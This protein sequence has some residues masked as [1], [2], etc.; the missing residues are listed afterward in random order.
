MSD[1]A[2]NVAVWLLEPGADADPAI[3][4]RD[5]AITR[6]ELRRRVDALAAALR[7]SGVARGDRVGVLSE[8]V[9]F[10][11]VSYLAAIRSGACVV[12]LAT[13]LDERGFRDAASTT[14]LRRLLVQ[15][16]YASR[17]LGWARAEGVALW[18]ERELEGAPAAEGRIP[19][20]RIHGILAALDEEPLDPRT[21][22]AAIMFTSGSTGRPKGV[23]VSHR[24]IEANTRDIADYL[25]LGPRDRVLAVLPL[26]YCFGASL[27]HTHLR[28][29]G[30]IALASSFMFPEKV[31]DELE[32]R[33][34]T[35][36]AGV[37]STYQILLRSTR[38]ARR[39]FPAL[40]WLQQAGGKLPDAFVRELR[41][42]HPGVALYCMYGQTEATARLSY[43][44]PERLD[45]KPGSIGRGLSGTRLEVLAEGGRPVAPEEETGEIVASGDNVCLGYW[46]DPEET[47]RFFRDGKLHTGDLARVDRDGFIYIVDRA[48]SFLKPM[49][50]RVSAR[51]IEEALAEL[52]DVIEAAV[53]GVPDEVWGEAVHAFVVSRP[54]SVLDPEQA[55]DHCARR[56]ANYKVPQR[57]SIVDALPRGGSGKVARE[58]LRERALDERT[59]GAPGRA[60][61]VEQPGRPH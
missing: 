15:E 31:L 54:G 29:G 52:P 22:L 40:R 32:L 33:G 53:V 18:P 7:A 2:R 50:N 38:F 35:G 1:A 60:Q 44:P 27:L 43:L 34:C 8:N 28:C 20:A 59:E 30:S 61:G 4:H 19:E 42:A 47:A 11:V 10:A 16:K 46:N 3:L 37:P 39:R 49:G 26:Y 5:V 41:A 48:R 23:M 9:P 36:L 24:N 14:G 12:P 55:R 17:A 51:E 25:A 58:R 57:V 56:L 6:G 45:D 21:A 13:D